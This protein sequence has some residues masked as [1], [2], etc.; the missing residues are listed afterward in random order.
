[1]ENLVE[2]KPNE[3]VT[4]INDKSNFAFID[5]DGIQ[6]K[7]LEKVKYVNLKEDEKPYVDIIVYDSSGNHWSYF[8]A[9]KIY[10]TVHVNK[11]Q[12]AISYSGEK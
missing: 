12:I 3:Y 5:A 2:I 7:T 4:I 8:N 9:T 1:M 6:S 11:N 10:Y